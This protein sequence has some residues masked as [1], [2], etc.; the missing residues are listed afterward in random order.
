MPTERLAMRRVREIL[1]LV[2]AKI[3]VRDIARR[4]GVAPST[5]REKQRRFEASG[6]EW[7]LPAELTDAV[8]ETRLYGVAGS[9]QGHRRRPEP[10]WARVNCELKRKHV[11]LQ[12]LWD[13]Y[14]AEYPDG[15]RYS[16]FCDL[17]RGWEARLPVTMRQLHLG[18]ERMFVDYAGDT[19]PVVIDRLT[20][21][22]RDAHLFVAVMAASSFSFAWPTWTESLPE[23]VDA[24]GRA[25][26]FFG[27]ATR[28]WCPTTPRSR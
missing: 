19:V 22:I 16:R 9:K 24:H 14:I 25:F 12:I 26:A 13:K 15:Y 3:A 8:L 21:E 23:W 6:M 28:F 18:G 2:D 10:D 27:G 4:L 17:Y 20:G 11:T 1:R 5:V 7:P